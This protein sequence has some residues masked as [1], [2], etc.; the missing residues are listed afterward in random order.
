MNSDLPETIPCTEEGCGKTMYLK[1]GQYGEFY[2][3]KEESAPKGYHTINADKVDQD[4]SRP[5]VKPYEAARQA[6]HGVRASRQS[7]DEKTDWDGIARGK[8]RCT[9]FNA[10]VAKE[11]IEVA[12]TKKHLIELAVNYVMNGTADEGAEDF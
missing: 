7:E 10:V 8:T 4:A 6:A 9:V 2:S 11:G 5:S 12:L 3:H 1:N